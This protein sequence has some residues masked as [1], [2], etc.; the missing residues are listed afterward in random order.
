MSKI[1]A[2][3]HRNWLL[4]GAAAAAVVTAGV[5]PTPGGAAAEELGP[6]VR[7]TGGSPFRGCTAD[8]AAG[9]DDPDAGIVNF[10]NTEIEPWVAAN[11]ADPD[12]LLA[13]WQQ[14]RWSNGGSR[15]LQAGVSRNG[16]ASWRTVTPGRVTECQG[17]RFAR[18]SDPWVDFSTAGVAYFMHLAFE[19]DLPSGAFGRNAMLVSRSTDGGLSW[20]RPITLIEDNDPRVLNDKNSLTADPT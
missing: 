1:D 18:A 10:P 5:A 2:P 15:G 14:D 16:G 20:Q 3:R 6:L 7:I 19:P 17:G 12:N 8:D 9:Q 13:G 11:P 4:A